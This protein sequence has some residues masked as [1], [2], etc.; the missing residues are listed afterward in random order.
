VYPDVF[1]RERGYTLAPA[2]PRER[3]PVARAR[4]KPVDRLAGTGDENLASA[5]RCRP[6]DSRSKLY[7]APFIPPRHS[8]PTFSLA[9]FLARRAFSHSARAAFLDETFP[10]RRNTPLYHHPAP[11]PLPLPPPPPMPITVAATTTT[12]SPRRD[13][14]RR[15]HV[16]KQ[17]PDDVLPTARLHAELPSSFQIQPPSSPLPLPSYHRFPPFIPIHPS[18]RAK[19]VPPFPPYIYPAR[20]LLYFSFKFH[21]T[22]STRPHRRA[23]RRRRYH[24]IRCIYPARAG[25]LPTLPVCLLSLSL[26]LASC[27]GDAHYAYDS[28]AARRVAGRTLEQRDTSATRPIL[29]R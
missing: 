8:P 5:S 3:A 2:C 23:S 11:L 19:S 29:I 10:A 24:D 22:F 21:P 1:K 15:F 26:S 17:Q 25:D 28:Q 18:A 9:L 6:P 4:S 16:Y 12:R 14:L 27:P 7:P 20:F 13:H